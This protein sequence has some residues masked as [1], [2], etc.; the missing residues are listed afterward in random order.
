MKANWPG[1]PVAA[2]QITAA[3]IVN[4][5]MKTGGVVSTSTPN[6]NA[7]VGVVKSTDLAPILDAGAV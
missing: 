7:Q 2:P 5:A 1:Q 6:V 3:T 4:N